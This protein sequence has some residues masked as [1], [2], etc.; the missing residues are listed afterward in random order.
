MSRSKDQGLTSIVILTYN[1]LDYNM[2]CIESIRQ[3]TE[4]DAYEIIVVDNNSAD[5]TV[6]WLKSQQDIQLILNSE[7]VG[8]PAGCNQGI[9]AARGDSILL[10]NNDTVVTPRWLD[11]L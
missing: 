1:K 7:N 11:N 10:L 9:K 6:E 3:Y 4:P 8:F 2:L 5:G